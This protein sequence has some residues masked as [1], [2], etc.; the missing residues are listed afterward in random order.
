MDAGSG[1][2]G[3]VFPREFPA[4]SRLYESRKQAISGRV[5]TALAPPAP[6]TFPGKAGLQGCLWGWQ[7]TPR[8]ADSCTLTPFVFLCALGLAQLLPHGC[9]WLRHPGVSQAR[10]L[11]LGVCLPGPSKLRLQPLLLCSACLSQCKQK[12][13]LR[14]GFP[15]VLEL[16]WPCLLACCP[17]RGHCEAASP[18]I[19][20]SAHHG[21][22]H[23]HL[24]ERG[25]HQGI[26][27]GLVRQES[28][29]EA[30]PLQAGLHT[31]PPCQPSGSPHA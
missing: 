4:T 31:S 12:R 14:W 1:P 5:H 2:Q 8:G 11:A 26:T 3:A 24:R 20:S 29:R 25:G 28:K 21:Y 13:F 7:W 23:L 9:T 27:G 22:T 19:T 6:F 18:E 30:A 17:W 16:A 15:Q 10:A